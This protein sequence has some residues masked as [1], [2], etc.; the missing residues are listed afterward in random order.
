M[1]GKFS[2]IMNFNCLF[3]ELTGSSETNC[4]FSPDIS[5]AYTFKSTQAL[6]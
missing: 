1:M 4:R 6:A 2:E 5:G 3:L